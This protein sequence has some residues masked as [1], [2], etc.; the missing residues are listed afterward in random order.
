MTTENEIKLAVTL[1]DVK[2]EVLSAQ[3]NY[4]TFKSPHE[5]FAIALEEMDGLWEEVKKK[6]HDNVAMRKEAIQTAA[7][8]TRFIVELL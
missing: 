2:R 1:Q 6:H 7:M 4:P 5:G 8:L 3:N